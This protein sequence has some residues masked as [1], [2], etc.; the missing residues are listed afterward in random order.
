MKT[1]FKT[2]LLLAAFGAFA[3]VSCTESQENKAENT[4]DAAIN[5][6]GDAVD[7]V[8]ADMATEPGDTAVVSGQPVD[9]A[10]EE[11]NK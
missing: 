7:S 4:T 9:G 6:T 2:L 1:S 8:Q 3:T 11:T 5:S 10:V